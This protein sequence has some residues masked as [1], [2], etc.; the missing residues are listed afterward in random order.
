MRALSPPPP[1]F[2]CF[3]VFLVFV[4]CKHERAILFML[5]EQA[6]FRCDGLNHARKMP[7][8]GG[9]CGEFRS[10]R[11]ATL[12]VQNLLHYVYSAKNVCWHRLG[13]S[14]A[15]EA[16]LSTLVFVRPSMHRHPREDY[17]RNTSATPCLCLL[18]Q[19]GSAQEER[20]TSYINH[21]TLTRLIGP[22]DTAVVSRVARY[23]TTFD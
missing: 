11:F 12:R 21:A 1:A 8:F 19:C 7:A 14:V 16:S 17:L 22:Q 23:V 18:F 5:Y 15:Y 6:C 3:L 2:G 9:E 4:G 13:V 10:M 20:P